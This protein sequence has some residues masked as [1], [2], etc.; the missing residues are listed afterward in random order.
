MQTRSAH[1]ADR[2]GEH[3]VA[4]LAWAPPLELD[5]SPLTSDASIRD[6]QWGDSWVRSPH[7]GTDAFAAKGYGGPLIHEDT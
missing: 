6:P 4:A 3:H 2:K 7:C 1:E 5:G